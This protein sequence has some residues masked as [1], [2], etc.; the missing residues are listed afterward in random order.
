MVIHAHAQLHRCRATELAGRLL[1]RSASPV[2]DGPDAAQTESPGVDWRAQSVG[3]ES[4]CFEGGFR[5]SLLLAKGP[6]PVV[7]RTVSC[8][9]R[10]QAGSSSPF[11]L[12]RHGGHWENTSSATRPEVQATVR[13]TAPIGA[14]DTLRPPA[15]PVT[16]PDTRS[17]PPPVATLEAT[18]HGMRIATRAEAHAIRGA[19]ASTMDTRD[20]A[21][22]GGPTCGGSLPTAPALAATAG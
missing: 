13:V 7:K 12:A 5:A 4:S 2:T 17:M 11:E 22:R 8:T 16:R 14:H 6:Q 1:C 15:S 19:L 9:R 3:W 20:R 21:S 18:V 10:R